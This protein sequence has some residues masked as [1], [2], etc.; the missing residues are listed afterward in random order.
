MAQVASHKVFCSG[1]WQANAEGL[2]HHGAGGKCA[3]A[4]IAGDLNTKVAAR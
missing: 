2:S 3:M 1:A 4:G